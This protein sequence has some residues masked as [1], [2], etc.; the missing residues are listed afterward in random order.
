MLLRDIMFGG[1]THFRELL[2]TPREG[3][4][5]NILFGRLAKLADAGL[6]SR[7]DDFPQTQ[8]RVLDG[9]RLDN[10]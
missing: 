7:E 9:P 5:S 8:G 1:F 3:I 2:T 10:T 6:L 4:A